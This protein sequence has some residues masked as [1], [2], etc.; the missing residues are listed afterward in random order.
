MGYEKVRGNKFFDVCELAQ[1]PLHKKTT[2]FLSA[3]G[4]SFLNLMT[5]PSTTQ[6]LALPAR[7]E[8]YALFLTPIRWTVLEKNE[9]LKVMVVC[10]YT[11]TSTNTYSQTV[12][13]RLRDR[14]RWNDSIGWWPFP[15][16]SRFSPLADELFSFI[17]IG[18]WAHIARSDCYRML[19]FLLLIFF[20]V[21]AGLSV[22][23]QILWCLAVSFSTQSMSLFVFSWKWAK[24]LLY[25]DQVQFTYI[26]RRAVSANELT[27]IMISV[28]KIEEILVPSGKQLLEM[29][30][31][32][33]SL[34]LC[35]DFFIGTICRRPGCHSKWCH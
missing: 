14:F 8:Q 13:A 10:L 32:T 16:S 19:I 9:N 24:F 6:V 17:S 20:S 15:S 27:L 31:E 30:P 4:L 7:S 12:P 2:R 35:N 5:Q 29:L 34:N 3:T 25:F 28:V 11:S 18:R 26:P 23:H 1:L 33:W 21:N 22:Y